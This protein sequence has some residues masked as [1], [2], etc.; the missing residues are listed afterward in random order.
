ML[1]HNRHHPEKRKHIQGESGASYEK[2]LSNNW[3]SIASKMS[4]VNSNNI[5]NNSSSYTWEDVF[6]KIKNNQ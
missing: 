4:Q 2:R 3:Y 5:F 6:R 1:V